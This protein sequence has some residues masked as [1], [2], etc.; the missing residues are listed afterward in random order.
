MALNMKKIKIILLTLCLITLSNSHSQF[1]IE[2]GYDCYHNGEYYAT[3]I[4]NMSCPAPGSRFTPR[5]IGDQYMDIH[6]PNDHECIV[7]RVRR[8][9][10]F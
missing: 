10:S 5:N 7:T 4:T 9:N 1:T 3:V 8:M 6:D 2:L